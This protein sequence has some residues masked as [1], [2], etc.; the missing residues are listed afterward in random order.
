MRL[1]L[2]FLICQLL[3]SANSFAQTLSGHVQDAVSGEQLLGATVWCEDT[4][5]GV[6][7]NIYG[8]Y[9]LTLPEGKHNIIVTY[10]GYTP[11]RFEIDLSI[12][13]KMDI[14]LIAGTKLKEAVVS[15][16]SLNKIEEQVQMSKM[17]IPIDQVKRLPAIGGEVD[18][19]K[20]L[21]LLPGVQSGGEG[22][23]GLYVRGGSPDQNLMLL[24]GV[25][26]YSVNHLF[27]FF[28]VFNADAVKNMSITKG[29]FPARFGGRLSS[30]L[31][32][33]MKDGHM[34]E[35]HADATVSIIA[36]KL[37]VEG[38]IVEDKASFMLSARRTYLDL[39]I[40][41]LISQ[42][43]RNNPDVTTDPRYY[44]YD[45]N[46]KLNWRI[47]SKD[48]LYLSAFKGE[49]DFGIASAENYGMY[50]STLDLGLDWKNAIQALRWNH[51]WGPRLF[52]N[53]TLTRSL[54]NF[55][56]G[57]EITEHSDDTL[58][59]AALYNSGIEDFSGR[60]DFDFAPN[61]RHYIKFGANW[62][63]HTF[64]PG[65]TSLELNFGDIPA[66]DTL[67]GPA[68]IKSDEAFLYIEDEFEL[69]ERLK[70]NLGIHTS[71]LMVQDTSYNSIQPRAAL[72]Y[73][74]PGGYALKTS[75]ARM[76]QY[77]NLLTNEGLGLPTD[78]WV[79]STAR[80]SPQQSWQVAMG[81]AK[82]FGDI[83]V[84]LEGYYKG[85]EGLLSYKEGASF[86][87]SLDTDW[88]DQVTQG[89]GNAYGTELLVQKKHGRTTG[90]IG[91]TLSWSNR[92][93]D[94]INSGNWYPYTYDR[95]HD[96]SFVVTHDFTEKWTGSAVWLYGTGRALTLSESSFSTYI[97]DGTG[98]GIYTFSAEVPSEKNA[99]RMSPYH[100]LD[101]SL[102]R[103]KMAE[104]GTRHLIFSVY[105]AY[106]N[107]NPFFAQTDEDDNGNP[108]IREYGIFPIIPS[109]AWRFSF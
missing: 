71:I 74:L 6:A 41:P 22:T 3:F 14:N 92:Q 46:G 18:L 98:E 99:F 37:T 89:I 79:P 90:W 96:V 29:G 83:E 93:F 24:D 10:I 17:E 86:L 70:L 56:T 38:P 55:N 94:D 102:T 81:V 21:Q 47:G 33:H 45:L 50:S 75:F 107:L 97:P 32:I 49:D 82:S 43:N 100:R 39:L 65:A 67:L 106:N 80:I 44:F 40:K 20:V 62:T 34:K 57:I 30:I 53:T 78:L 48:R 28:S 72:N 77:V 26:L 105:N 69:S 51:E 15:A 63:N 52:S 91:Y 25:P 68:D 104:N 16:E 109:I 88:E 54:Y 7:A 84:S 8:F 108:V 95:R 101:L 23:S 64:S 42:A 76:S 85:M 27:G 13:I 4:K 35:Y 36:S 59:M 61:A 9:S 31:E 87:F 1:I 12:N 2:L 58:S 19:L 66:L 5:Q 60:I 73:R 11:Q 103:T